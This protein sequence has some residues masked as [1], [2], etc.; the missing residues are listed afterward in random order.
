MAF[1]SLNGQQLYFSCVL[2]KFSWFIS[3]IAVVLQL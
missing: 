2:R 3:V 1:L